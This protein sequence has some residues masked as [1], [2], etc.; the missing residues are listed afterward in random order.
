MRAGS[1][2]WRSKVTGGLEKGAQRADNRSQTAGG[3][4]GAPGPHSEW[5]DLSLDM[6]SFNLTGNVSGALL[7][8]LR[9][10]FLQC[11]FQGS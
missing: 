8:F 5:A 11:M 1:S 2:V 10:P 3:R 9:F 4:A 7:D 6:G